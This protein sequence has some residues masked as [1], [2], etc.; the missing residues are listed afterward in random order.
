MKI[1]G[2]IG[3]RSRDTEEDFKLVET[4]FLKVYREGD[5]ICSGQSPHGGGRFAVLLA[6]KYKTRTLWY[7]PEWKKYGRSAGL[8][9]NTDIARL[10]DI[11]IACV[12][13]NRTGGTE[14]TINKYSTLGK[15]KLILVE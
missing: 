7:P 5:T 6:K 2:I 10:S 4:V 11:L 8:I 13:T 3:T 12:S 1:I 15:T 14:D 9:R